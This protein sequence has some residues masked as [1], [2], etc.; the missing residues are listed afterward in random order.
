MAQSDPDEIKRLEALADHVRGKSRA[1]ELVRL[2]EA[3]AG[4]GVE[5]A[6]LAESAAA[7]T[8]S[9]LRMVRAGTTGF[10]YSNRYMTSAY[11]EA[12]ARAETGDRL[13]MISAAV[14][15]DSATYPRPTP[16]ETVPRAALPSF[17]G[18]GGRGRGTYAGER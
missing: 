17:R 13:Q 8:V 4:M 15:F 10:L 18:R 9:D 16:I 2:D 11:A 5:V 14:R 12:A 6:G 3:C 1:G 7:V